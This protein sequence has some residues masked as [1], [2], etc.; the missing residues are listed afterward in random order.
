MP[1]EDSA[2]RPHLQL[3]DPKAMRAMAHPT[4]IALLEALSLRQPLTAT[5]AAGIVGESPTNC[6]FHLRT[7]AKYG[8]VEED[9]GGPG[10]RRPW[11]LAHHGFRLD[12]S[13]GAAGTETRLAADALASLVVETWTERIR[14]VYA[15]RPGFP[16]VWRQLTTS[17]STVMFMTVEESE[18][19]HADVQ[20]L[21][22]RYE[23][24]LDHP[25]RRP[26]DCLPVEVIQFSHPLDAAGP[27]GS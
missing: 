22:R 26:E 11:R 2:Q 15:R 14:Q 21:F 10:R 8:F 7:L 23:D 27:Q 18:R 13:V 24:R 12:S 4:R 25:S 3:T 17:D 20:E 19:F 16:E 9:G 5:E 6:A 1:S